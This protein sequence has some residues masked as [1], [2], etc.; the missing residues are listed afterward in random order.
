MSTGELIRKRRLALGL[1]QEELARKVKLT[2]GMIS[3]LETGFRVPTPRTAVALEKAL[4]IP[5][6]QLVFGDA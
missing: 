6:E 3:H 1:S 4:G 5:K 2:T